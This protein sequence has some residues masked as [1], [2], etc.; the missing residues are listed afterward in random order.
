MSTPS[1]ISPLAYDPM[2]E[3]PEESEALAREGLMTT[4]RGIS[5]TTYTDSG[6]AT[7]SVHAKS[8][9]LLLGE[10]RVMDGLPDYLAQGLF[11]KPVTLPIVMRFS[12]IPGDMLDDNVST[13]RGLAIKVVGVEGARLIGTENA[14]TQ[15]FLLVNGPAFLTPGPQQFLSNLKFLAATT[16]RVPD[17]K[18]ALSTILQRAEKL[19]ESVGGESATIKTIGGHLETNILGEIYFSQAP[20]LYGEYMAKISIAPVSD[21]LVQLK[22]APVDLKNKPNGLREAV[23]DFFSSNTAE[24]ELR[25]QLCTDLESM[26]IEDASVVWPEE[27]SPYIAVARIIVKPQLAWSE[28]RSKMIDDGMSFSPW[29]GI[30]AHRPIGSIMRV[31]KMAYEMSAKFRAEHNRTSMIEPICLQ[32]FP[33]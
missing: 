21:S 9:G 1:E 13:P 5:E 3:V 26:P 11:A 15:D 33:I 24:W 16:N 22:N 20:I 17:L 23:V 25:V 12:T 30:E 6:H 8:H 29:H 4:L 10:I 14:V 27:L 18:R 28:A 7:R 19:I 2:Y 31:R 32:N